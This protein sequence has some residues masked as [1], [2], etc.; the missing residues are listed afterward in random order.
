MK[1][2]HVI[3]A[4]GIGGAEKLLLD[5]INR[6]IES[7]EVHLIYL[8]PINDLISE[9]DKRIFVKQI[10]LSFSTIKGLSVYYDKVNADIIH[11]H[12]GHADILGVWAAK[13]TKSKLFS[14]IHSTSF[15]GNGILDNIYFSFY[16]FLF[17]KFKDR[18]NLISISESVKRVVIKK[19][20][21]S[22]ENNLVLRNAI[23]DFDTY[24]KPHNNV[25]SILFL[26]R[27]TKA[28]S[29]ETLLKAVSQIKENSKGLIFRVTIVGEGNLK[30]RLVKL[31][32][33]L[34]IEN[35]VT[36]I[37]E[38][39][40]VYEFYKKA[41]IFILPSIWEGFG[42]VILEAFRAKLAVIASDIE[43][44]SELIQDN[45]NGLLFEP[46]NHIQLAEK[47]KL[48]I[49]NKTLRESLAEE[50]YNTFTA[51]FHINTYVKKLEELYLNV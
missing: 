16:R 20:T 43:G 15:K 22:K 25:V 14:T 8:K 49:E 9:V 6:Q 30:Q 11:T 38:Q 17:N 28:K 40:K 1:I 26:G 45:K 39:K 29:I 19:I 48:L 31:T 5:I 18:W 36:F 2:I 37:G 23:S 51:D 3:T 34:K 10:P 4:F 47:M 24:N 35:I 46:K 13:R 27:L 32:K 7:H 21:K 12:L 33:K 42:I 41:D 44:P 50:G